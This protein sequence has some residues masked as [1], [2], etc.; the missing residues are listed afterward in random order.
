MATLASALPSMSNVA[1]PPSA[2]QKGPNARL[3]DLE[4]PY[5]PP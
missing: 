5:F 2:L 1:R 3:E 4:W